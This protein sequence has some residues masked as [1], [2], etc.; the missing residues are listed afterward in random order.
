MS[1]SYR[2][3]DSIMGSGKTTKV[4]EEL[5]QAD[6]EQQRF[7]VVTPYLPEVA[8]ITTAVPQLDFVSPS[9]GE[10]TKL[11][12]L[13]KLLDAGRNIASTHAL[14]QR[15]SL[16]TLEKLRT[17]NYQLIIDETVDCTRA[18]GSGG[19]KSVTAA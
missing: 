9:D 18:Y 16:T 1:T 17:H 5:R 3:I 14:F 2:A 8:R 15:W 12:A 6:P 4:I 11:A 19:E 10:G 13:H 7:I